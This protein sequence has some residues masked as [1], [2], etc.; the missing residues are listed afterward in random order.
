[1]AKRAEWNLP[2]EDDKIQPLLVNIQSWAL[3]ICEKKMKVDLLNK[4]KNAT[5]QLFIS[6]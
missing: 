2:T 4:T 6:M 5:A 1:M 3:V